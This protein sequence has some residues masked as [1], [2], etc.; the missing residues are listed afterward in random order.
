MVVFVVVETLNYWPLIV[1]LEDVYVPE[2]AQVVI[3]TIE[4]VDISTISAML[5]VMSYRAEQDVAGRRN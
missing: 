4:E 1:I 3:E 5:A 2:L